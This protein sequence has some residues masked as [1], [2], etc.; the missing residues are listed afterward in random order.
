M[1]SIVILIII[2]ALFTLGVLLTGVLTMARGKD[3]TGK[4]SNKLMQMRVI[5]QA[6]TIVLI[7]IFIAV[8]TG[9]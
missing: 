8:A 1:N 4:K 5:A 6:V 7:L 9:G 3:V 2:A